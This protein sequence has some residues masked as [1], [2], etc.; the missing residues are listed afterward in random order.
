MAMVGFFFFVRI[1]FLLT[2]LPRFSPSLG[3]VPRNLKHADRA[4]LLEEKT[5]PH[6]LTAFFIALK[7]Y[8][9]AAVAFC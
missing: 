7:P 4:P 6:P 5:E 1:R 2:L 8:L 9:K 3:L